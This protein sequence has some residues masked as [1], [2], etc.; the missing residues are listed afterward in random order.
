MEKHEDDGTKE[1]V[2]LDRGLRKQKGQLVDELITPH[3]R[4][5]EVLGPK[6]HI[7][8]SYP[9]TLPDAQPVQARGRI[10]WNKA[11]DFQPKG[12]SNLDGSGI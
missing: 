6:H 9:A 10:V 5:P 12:P 7:V 8:A 2:P 4:L 11:Y 3:V 1:I